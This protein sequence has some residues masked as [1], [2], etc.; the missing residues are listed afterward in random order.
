M[1]ELVSFVG[2]Y[3]YGFLLAVGFAE[4]VGVPIV[5]VPVLVT[6]GAVA[7]QGGIHPLGA[8]LAAAAGG[9]LADMTWY[10]M[11][12]WQGHR[13]VGVA[14]GLTSNPTAC[15]VD[16]EER[17]GRLGPRLILPAKFLPG[18]GNLLAPASGFA[19]VS[20]WLF[21]WADAAALLL[22]AVAYTGVGWLFSDQV[23]RVLE[24]IA[25]YR[26]SALWIGGGLILGAAVWRLARAGVHEMLHGGA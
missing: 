18:V 25:A 13:L 20:L 24:A 10:G 3:G 17:V 6:V 23:Y 2:E 1:Y 9:L 14:C 7:G 5:S 22:W 21:L 16:V 8:A 11:G 26:S 19:G 15:V 4:F 12:R